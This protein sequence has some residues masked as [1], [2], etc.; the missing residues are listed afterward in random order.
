MDLTNK[1]GP[2]NRFEFGI[3]PIFT[4]NEHPFIDN[5]SLKTRDTLV[6]CYH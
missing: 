1:L 3:T 6:D 5:F 4:M 2:W